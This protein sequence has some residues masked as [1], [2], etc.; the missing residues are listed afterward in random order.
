MK[1]LFTLLLPVLFQSF[2]LAQ[3]NPTLTAAY[4]D[5]RQVVKLRWQHT[6]P[7][8]T[9]YIIQ[10]SSDNT[11]FNDIYT[12]KNTG[13]SANEYLRF[14]DEK[15]SPGKNYYRLKIYRG[16]NMYETTIPVMVVLGNPG[17]SWLIY[18]V[19]AGPVL[20]LQY[21]GTDLIS[22]VIGVTIT[23]V[24]SGTVF[25]RLRLAST[26]RFI[27]LPVDNIGRGVY[28]IRVYIGDKVV[29]NQR[30]NK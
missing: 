9:S 24:S 6:D 20:N 11:L 27:Q 2:A 4:E 7:K 1:F 22:G 5:D 30:F 17:G 18:P 19:P 16:S 10:R 3:N 29:W 23:S 15:N 26:T 8:V 25:T 21:N 28:D 13:I 14:T 12:R